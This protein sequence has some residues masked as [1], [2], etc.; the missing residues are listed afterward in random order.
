MCGRSKM[1]SGCSVYL[2]N[3]TLLQLD[4]YVVPVLLELKPA[5]GLILRLCW[6][7]H[8][9]GQMT[10]WC[11]SHSHKPLRQ[12]PTLLSGVHNTGKRC[13]PRTKVFMIGPF[14]VLICQL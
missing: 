3:S 10:A 12:T 9:A 14:Y 8:T 2:C 4:L 6:N 7:P 13:P 1:I 11:V 5:N